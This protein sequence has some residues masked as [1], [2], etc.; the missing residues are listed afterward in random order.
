MDMTWWQGWRN[1]SLARVAYW[2]A[3]KA[4]VG[5]R[6][7]MRGGIC[8][9]LRAVGGGSDCLCPE[10]RGRGLVW[11]ME[12]KMLES[13]PQVKVL[14]W[15]S[16]L[17]WAEIWVDRS[18]GRVLSAGMAVRMGGYLQVLLGLYGHR[19]LT[20]ALSGWGECGAENLPCAETTSLTVFQITVQ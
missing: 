1:G 2:Q 19:H 11:A 12:T 7:R 20:S 16:I 8:V 17:M 9:C 14:W 18:T 6:V 4:I 5:G 3:E 13:R 15:E 10:Q